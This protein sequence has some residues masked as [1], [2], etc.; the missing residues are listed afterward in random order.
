M[1]VK[2]GAVT[3][4]CADLEDERDSELGQGDMQEDAS[5]QLQQEL[6]EAQ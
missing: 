6:S 4:E 1:D 2:I 3:E 5:V